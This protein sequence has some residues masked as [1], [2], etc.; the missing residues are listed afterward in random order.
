MK[1]FYITSLLVISFLW[2]NAQNIGISNDG[3]FT[4]PQSPLHIYWTSDGNL[5]QL[6][7]SSAANTGLTFSV[8]SN[9][10]SILNRQNN[11]LIFGTNATE[12][13][14]ITNTGNVGIGTSA[15]ATQLHTTGTVRFAGYSSG[16]SG[17]ILRTNSSG[18]LSITNFS[19]TATDVLLGSGSFGS[20]NS[21][22]WQLTGNSG[23]NPTTNFIGTTDAQDFIFKTNNNERIRVFS[24]G[25]VRIGYGTA[26]TDALQIGGYGS[27]NP[28]IFMGSEGGAPGYGRIGLYGTTYGTYSTI[29]RGGGLSYFNS[30]NQYVFG[31]TTAVDPSDFVGIVGNA[32]YPFALNAYTNQNNASAIFGYNNSTIAS[33]N[34]N[35]IYGYTT[36]SSGSAILGFLDNTTADENAAGIYGATNNPSGDAGYFS[37]SAASSTNNGNGIYTSTSQSRGAGLFSINKHS[38]GIA[39]IGLGGNYL[40]YYTL[41]GGAGIEGVNNTATGLGSYFRNDVSN[42]NS[43]S[44]IAVYAYSNASRTTNIQAT[45]Y[46]NCGIDNVANRYGIYCRGRLTATGTKS[47]LFKAS[48]GTTRLLYCTESPEVWYEDIGFGQLN[49]G[50]AII[51]LDTLFLEAVTINEKHPMHIFIQ[52]EGKCSGGVYVE[53][54]FDKFK[55]IQNDGNDSNASFSYRVIAKRKGNEDERFG[56]LL[57]IKEPEVTIRKSKTKS[58]KEDIVS[59]LYVKK[60]K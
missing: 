8:S 37:N 2:L 32:T 25:A 30:G 38:N 22:A 53:K 43:S 51:Y 60:N 14:R 55:V 18:D 54:E 27:T 24:S 12:R 20:M 13:M 45:V 50:V 31:Q 15:P 58:K 7:R 19:G 9:D 56:I 47:S 1:H 21:L 26:A 59:K 23:T 3:T 34:A 35:G 17:A 41:T 49:N 16:A 28:T 57:P 29:I 39:I 36:N 11:A 33:I 48:D 52:L 10:Y 42:T 46:A 4:T 40:S 5:L 44:A 6:S